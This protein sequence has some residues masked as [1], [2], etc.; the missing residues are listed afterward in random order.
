MAMV[1]IL[2]QREAA[3]ASVHEI[4]ELECVQFIDSDSNATK[5]AFQRPW[6]SEVRTCDDL[7]RQLRLFRAAATRLRLPTDHERDYD[8]A[9]TL[10]EMNANFS[11]LEKELKDMQTRQRTMDGSYAEKL[12]HRQ[13]LRSATDELAFTST[14]QRPAQ[15]A[16]ALEEEGTGLLEEGSG[17]R[18]LAEQQGPVRMIWGVVEMDKRE[19]L[20]RLLFRATRGNAILKTSDRSHFFASAEGAPGTGSTK[21]P[22]AV[23]FSGRS[24]QDKVTKICQSMDVHSYHVPRSATEQIALLDTLEREIQDH[25]AVTAMSEKR[26]GD[27]LAPVAA[28]LLEG[29]KR[30][31]KEKAVWATLNLFDTSISNKTVVAEGWVPVDK[32]SDVRAALLRG[33][34]RSRVSSTSVMSL[35]ETDATPPTLIKTNKLTCSFQALND[36][37]G[38]PRYLEL[39]PG[40]FYPVTYSFLFGIMFGDIGHGILLLLGALFLISRE[41][42]WG[43]KKLN[44]LIEPAFEGRYV[45]LLMALFSIYVGGV[46]N[47]CFGCSLL[48][49]SY[50]SLDCPKEGGQCAA[51]PVAPPGFGVDPI[52]GIAE[53]KLGYQN[54]F[55]M[56][57]SIIIGVSQMVFGLACKT[58]NC[59]YFKKWKDLYYENIPEYVF[60]LS[61]FGYLCLLIVYKWSVDWVGLG[62]AAP[63]LLDTLLGMVLD[64][65]K[66]I[67][68]D[69]VLYPGQA[70]VQM[71]LVILAVVSVPCMLFPKPYLLRAENREGYAQLET[72]DDTEV[73]PR[74]AD[75]HGIG[76]TEHK[77]FDFQECMIHQSIHVIEFVLGSVSNTASYLRLWALSLAHGGL[78]EVFW[79]RVMLAALEVEAEP[80]VKAVAMFFAFSVWA[81]LTFGVLMVM[82][83]LSACLHD[84][85]LHW[86]E[87]QNKFYGADGKP[88]RPLSF[89]TVIREHVNGVSD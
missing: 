15:P 75:A 14:L 41:H 36:A 12:E 54:S 72:E 52:W 76:H 38:T 55:K 53:N 37:Y 34:R 64:F 50:W 87:F 74:E 45:L 58:S 32:I 51:L 56:K 43:G 2:M 49:W 57:I 30:V 19:A 48:P 10:D 22:F 79:E 88:F 68:P 73:A 47:E 83:T 11:E 89:K 78:S 3:H 6:V 42:A 31:L 33:M 21:V 29:E 35:I 26:Q 66:P 17:L 63:P 7:L 25:K 86:V 1:Q 24:I 85:R 5:T 13:V 82:E 46:Y 60:L 4:A 23:V 62:L 18:P 39:N 77:E 59:F 16:G 70:T 40:I 80:W 28:R 8:S 20:E 71:I 61:I 69:M 81:C 84:I 65:G 67:P 27:L 44:E 9:E